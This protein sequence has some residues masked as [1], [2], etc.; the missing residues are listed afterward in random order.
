V[1][2]LLGAE[3]YA[4]ILREGLRKG[5]PEELVAQS[6]VLGWILS[7]AVGER[8]AGRTSGAY[9]CRLD[10]DLTAL[11]QQFWQQEETPRQ[12]APWTVAET[13]CE[14]LFR[15]SQSRAKDGR[16]IVRL[17][18]EQLPDFA[19]TRNSALRVL[20]SMQR[21]FNRDEQL[22][23]RYSEFMRQYEN[24]EHMK[25]VEGRKKDSERTCYL[26]HHGV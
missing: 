13:E 20:Q 16:Y 8:S 2:I 21:R 9:Q 11:M 4:R 19:V 25:P 14:D 18:F 10:K 26:P 23:Q 1:D 15:R 17:P 5:G 24:L 3:I 6:T 22:H 7:D 12:A